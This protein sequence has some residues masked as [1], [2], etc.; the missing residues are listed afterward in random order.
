MNYQET[1]LRYARAIL[2]I[3]Q[4]KGHVD[5]VVS[6]MEIVSK[7]VQ[8]NHDVEDFLT[9]PVMKAQN[10]EELLKSFFENQP[11]REEIQSLLY[12]LVKKRRFFLLPQICK[13]LQIEVDKLEGVARGVVKSSKE[14]DVTQRNSLE[15]VISEFTGKKIHL[16][17]KE[18][19]NLIGGIV[20]QVGSY[21]FDDSLETQIQMM[22]DDLIKA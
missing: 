2:S 13:A 17:Y 18:D 1:S 20:A 8:S 19:K 14:L 9:S 21:T 10:Q 7:Q 4:E 22:R 15:K 5:S 11:L 12:L 3:A 6:Q 16:E